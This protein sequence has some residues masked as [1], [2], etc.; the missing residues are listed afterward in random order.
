LKSNELELDINRLRNTND[1]STFVF[2]FP[3]LIRDRVEPESDKSEGQPDSEE[4]TAN[5]G[6]GKK[7]RRIEGMVG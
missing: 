1:E 7:S 2:L 4:R 5:I 3:S 6:F